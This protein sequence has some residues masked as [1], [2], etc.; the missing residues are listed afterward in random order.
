MVIK[1]IEVLLNRITNTH[2]S[3]TVRRQRSVLSA[4]AM[5]AH[6]CIVTVSLSAKDQQLLNAVTAESALALH[7]PANCLHTQ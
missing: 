3:C 2:L 1:F 4:C 5:F 7:M 6:V